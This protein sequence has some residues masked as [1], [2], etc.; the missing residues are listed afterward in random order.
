MLELPPIIDEY[1]HKVADFLTKIGFSFVASR[2]QFNK[3]EA[4]MAREIDLLFTYQNCLFIIEVSTVKSGRNFKILAFM[5]RWS[6]QKNFERLKQKHPDVP[7]NVMRI[8]FDLSKDTPENKSQDVEELT[9]DLG[10]MV[11]YKDVFEKLNSTE[12]VEQVIT[13]FLGNDWFVK[14]EKFP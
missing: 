14:T 8:F 7:N 12:N 9:E 6:K 1:E 2:S 3:S 11:I 5:Y 4:E 10:N 13:D